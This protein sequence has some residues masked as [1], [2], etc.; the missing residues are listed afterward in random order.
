[1]KQSELIKQL[2]DKELKLNLVLSQMLFL[3]IALVLSLFLFEDFNNWFTL[4]EW[5][6]RDLI[7]LGFFPPLLIVGV[8][9]ILMRFLPKSVFDDG[10]I[11]ERI[12]K[13]QP[14][15]F[16]FW[17]SLL[18]AISEE[19]LFRGVIQSTFGF[20]FASILFA[21]VHLRYLRKPV[22]FTGVL[23]ISLVIGYL[24]LI[25]ENLLV[26]ITFHFIVDFLLGLYIRFKS[27]VLS[28]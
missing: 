7:I 19:M 24:F 14:V 13:N 5:N 3:A 16:I 4:F 28:D 11:N 8:D 23:I 2:S 10:G 6:V 20:V 12:F 21:V 9:L 26:T 22:L 18:V 17:I 27:E 25:T 1:M 15:S